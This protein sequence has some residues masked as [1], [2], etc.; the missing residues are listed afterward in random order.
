MKAR[1]SHCLDWLGAVLDKC[2]AP[3]PKGSVTIRFKT[4]TIDN[5]WMKMTPSKQSSSHKGT[6]T[7]QKMQRDGEASKPL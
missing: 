5:E 6:I 1:D 7:S 4:L 3:A 2:Q